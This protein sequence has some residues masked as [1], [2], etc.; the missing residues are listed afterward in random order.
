MGRAGGATVAV[1]TAVT[2]ITIHL[3]QFARRLHGDDRVRVREPVAH[4]RAA[5]ARAGPA[6]RWRTHSRRCSSWQ[7]IRSG[8]SRSR[9]SSCCS[10]ASAVVRPGDSARRGD[11]RAL[12]AITRRARARRRRAAL[13]SPPLLAASVQVRRGEGRRGRRP[14]I[15]GVLERPRL[16]RD[17]LVGAGVLDL[18]WGLAVVAGIVVARVPRPPRRDRGRGVAPSAPASAAGPHRLIRGL[19]PRAASV[20][21]PPRLR[22]RAGRIRARAGPSAGPAPPARRGGHCG[23]P[24]AAPRVGP[25]R[26]VEL[27]RR[28]ARREPRAGGGVRAAR[29]AADHRG[30][31]WAARRPAAARRLRRARRSGPHVAGRLEDA[32]RRQPLRVD[33]PARAA[34]VPAAGLAHRLDQAPARRRGGAR[35]RGRDDV[36]LRGTSWSRYPRRATRGSEASCTSAPASGA[37]SRSAIPACATS[38]GWRASTGSRRISTP[39]TSARRA[40]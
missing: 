38:A 23:A 14:D 25:K 2:P 30:R 4:A 21:S 39:R 3:A 28:P 9:R 16:A 1:V 8:S 20:V 18:L 26:P 12:V 6:G 35:R 11:R 15:A 40:D 37:R 17:R 27:Q 24:H 7:R 34:A 5:F 32:R 19:R 29:R 13:A 10:P 36:D 33:P 31:S 22:D